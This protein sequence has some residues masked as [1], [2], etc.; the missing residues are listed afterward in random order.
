[1]FQSFAIRKNILTR[2]ELGTDKP[3]HTTH[4]WPHWNSLEQVPK[5][6]RCPGAEPVCRIYEIKWNMNNFQ[7]FGGVYRGMFPPRRRHSATFD[8]FYRA[9]SGILD[10]SHSWSGIYGT[11]YRY[12]S[13]WYRSLWLLKLSPHDSDPI[14]TTSISP[15]MSSIMISHSYSQRKQ[16]SDKTSIAAAF[17]LLINFHIFP[18]A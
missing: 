8:H 16:T 2:I 18:G 4:I 5:A 10:V 14:Y 17:Y 3:T 6:Q 9:F 15:T 13:I 1:M 12:F 11:R 7:Q